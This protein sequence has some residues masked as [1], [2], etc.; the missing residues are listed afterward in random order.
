[1]KIVGSKSA[2]I[3]SAPFDPVFIWIVFI[4]GC[5][6]TTYMIPISDK[7][8]DGENGSPEDFALSKSGIIV[9]DIDFCWNQTNKQGNK[10][11]IATPHVWGSQW[12]SAAMGIV[13][14]WQSKW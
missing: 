9:S 2:Y 12:Q 1:M 14:K 4:R 8:G 11:E 10:G 7:T 6:L 5:L 3:R 13:D